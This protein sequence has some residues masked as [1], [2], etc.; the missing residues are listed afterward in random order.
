MSRQSKERRS[1]LGWIHYIWLRFGL[2][3]LVAMPIAAFFMFRAQGFDD[4]VLSSDSA[5]VVDQS[6]LDA[7]TFVP[8]EPRGGVLL[9]PGC[10]PDPLAY[11]PFARTLAGEQL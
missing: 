7:I 9:I 6:S 2:F 1:I 4:A 10:P 5:L 8:R 11:A 3:M